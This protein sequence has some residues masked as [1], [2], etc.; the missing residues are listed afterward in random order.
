MKHSMQKMI[1]NFT[2]TG[3]IPTREMTPHVPLTPQEIASDILLCAELGASMVHIHAR[4][5]DGS[6][7]YKKEVYRDI[8]TR[9]RKQ[10]RDIVIVVSTSGRTFA[11]FEKRAEVLELDGEAK[12]DMASLT[13]GSINFNKV[14]SI[15]PPEVIMKLARRMKERGIKPE[16]EVFDLGM[17]NCARY[18]IGKGLLDPPYYFNFILGN[19]AAAQASLLH[20]GL[21]IRELPENSFWSVGGVGRWQKT[22]NAIGVVSGEGGVRVGL[23]DNIWY[24]DKRTVLATNAMLVERVVQLAAL[25]DRPL[26]T[27]RDARDMLE[28]K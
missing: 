3:M 27:A 5:K 20:L 26:A 22:M 6:N 11:D 21:L 17:V 13:L 1:I 8:I 16:L 12:P 19:I 7:T 14:A 4:D 25:V 2:P 23:E 18:L 28:L 10:N 24:D 15:N 9:V